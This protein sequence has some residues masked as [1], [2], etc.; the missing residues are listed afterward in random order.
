MSEHYVVFDKPY[1]GE[2]TKE[3]LAAH[4]AVVSGACEHCKYLRNCESGGKGW[5]VFQWNA[6]CMVYMRE[7]G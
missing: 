1:P 6:P 5:T 2:K 3:A 4:W 7:K